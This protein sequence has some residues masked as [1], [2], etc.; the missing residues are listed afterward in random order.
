MS[1][2][3]TKPYLVRAIY[4]WCLDQ[5][6]TPYIAVA[7]DERTVVPP[8]YARDGQIVL[9]LAPDATNHL[10]MGNDLITF[11]ARFGGV[12]HALSLPVAN[13]L[14]IY[15]RENGHGMAFEQEVAGSEPLA[16][17]DATDEVGSDAGDGD[18]PDTPSAAGRSAS[19]NHLK[20]VK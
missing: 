14:A 7:V 16:D 8:G 1:K 13:V 19:R 15:A 5:G 17:E 11:Q 20:V 12:A 10:V 18:G 9:N 3:S 2:V 4:D 6:F